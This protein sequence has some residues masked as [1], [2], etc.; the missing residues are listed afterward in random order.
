MTQSPFCRYRNSLGTP[1]HGVHAL[2]TIYGD[3][4]ANDVWM[5]V[6]ASLLLALLGFRPWCHLREFF[7]LWLVAL[8]TLFGLGILLHRLF[9]VRTTID[10]LLFP[11]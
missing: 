5:T 2:R 9:C 6:F 10:R 4:A 3:L 11:S 1:R 8:A 7:I